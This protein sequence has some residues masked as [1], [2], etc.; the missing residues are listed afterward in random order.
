M[1]RLLIISGVI[2]VIIG[3]LLNM[4]DSRFAWF[5][6]L[7][8]DFKIIKSSYKLYFPLSSM[9]VFSIFLTLFANII[10]RIFR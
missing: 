7:Y 4:F 5:G 6:N 3:I 10:I 9:I 2:I 1:G 8:G